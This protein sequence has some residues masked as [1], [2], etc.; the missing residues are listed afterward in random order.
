MTFIR[1]L[2]GF[3]NLG[4]DIRFTDVNDHQKSISGIRKL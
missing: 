1:F 2:I 3:R 4:L